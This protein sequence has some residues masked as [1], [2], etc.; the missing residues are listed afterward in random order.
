MN[1]RKEKEEIFTSGILCGVG[2]V[3]IGAILPFVIKVNIEYT[4]MLYDYVVS[5]AQ[6]F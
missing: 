5:I 3:I 1:T 6:G 2:S 4:V